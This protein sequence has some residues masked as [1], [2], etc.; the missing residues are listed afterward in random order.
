[1][2][3]QLT[4]FFELKRKGWVQA[5]LWGGEVGRNKLKKS[6]S[7]VSKKRKGVRETGCGSDAG[8]CRYQ[9]TSR[10]RYIDS[11]TS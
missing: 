6:K 7:A 4:R 1:M 11:A 5:A 2:A 3:G 8:A 9:H 10:P